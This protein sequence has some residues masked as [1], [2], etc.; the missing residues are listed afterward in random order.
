MFIKKA[1]ETV[2]SR[3]CIQII[4]SVE[5]AYQKYIKIIYLIEELKIVLGLE[6]FIQNQ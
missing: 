6:V 3:K 2:S 5:I 1:A 4:P